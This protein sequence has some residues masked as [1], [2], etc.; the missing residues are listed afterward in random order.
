MYVQVNDL[1]LCHTTSHMT[2]TPHQYSLLHERL[3]REILAGV[4]QIGD[5]L[6]SENELSERENL[7]RSTIRQALSQLEQEGYITKQRGKGSIVASR[8]RALGVL[9]FQGFSASVKGEDISALSVQVPKLS[10]WPSDFYF[11]LSELEAQAGCISFSRVRLIA[12]EPVMWETT[13]VPHLNLPKFT[14]LFD[15]NQSFF[16]FL[17]KQYQIEI[18]GMEQEIKAIRSEEPAAQ[19]LGVA[20]GAPLLHVRRKYRTNRPV[21]NI[22]SE[23]YCNT[24]RYAMSNAS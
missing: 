2:Q 6:P 22:Y 11:D 19:H 7:A 5:L 13:F 15:L 21:L 24:E 20:L 12:Q 17:G 4:Y 1:P 23:L 8:K 10:K 18:T 9:S 14:K 16:E 3:K